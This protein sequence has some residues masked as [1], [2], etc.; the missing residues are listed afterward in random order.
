[1]KQ[2]KLHN[3]SETAKLLLDLASRA[4]RD[5]LT[6]FTDPHI[7]LVGHSSDHKREIRIAIEER[8]RRQ[9]L[10]R[11]KQKKLLKI[12]QIGKEFEVRLTDEGLREAFRLQVL[13]SDMLE[14]ESMCMVVFDVP[15]VERSSRRQIRF[16]LK[17]AVFIPIQKSVWISPFDASDALMNFFSGMDMKGWVRIFRSYEVTK[18]NDSKSVRSDRI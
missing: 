13:N 16:L 14:D 1:M 7:G 17:E 4:S 3:R 11:L 18:N 9:A 12:K 15:E 8:D 6:A 5:L 10:R 2:K